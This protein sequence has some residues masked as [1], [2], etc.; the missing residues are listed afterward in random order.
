MDLFNSLIQR[1]NWDH[2]VWTKRVPIQSSDSKVH[3]VVEYK[4]FTKDHTVIGTYESLYVMTLKE[5]KWKNPN[6]VQLRA[7]KEPIAR[8]AFRPPREHPRDR[9]VPLNP[10]DLP[11]RMS[12]LLRQ[13]DTR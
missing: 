12:P 9:F 11:Q 10:P 1:S 8:E 7:V 4:R 2:S 13:G 3:W 5:G 6:P